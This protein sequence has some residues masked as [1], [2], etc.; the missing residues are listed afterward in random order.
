MGF[1]SWQTSD[2]KE[3]IGNT[4]TSHCKTVYLLQP[5]GEPPIKETQYNGYGVFGGVDAYDWLAEHNLPKSEVQKIIDSG[6][7]YALRIHAIENFAPFASVYI[8]Q[9]TGKI[10]RRSEVIDLENG[11][12]YETKQERFGGRSINELIESGDVV[13]ELMSDHNLVEYPL[14]FS[15]DEHAVY[16]NLPAAE[17]CPNQGFFFADIEYEEDDDCEFG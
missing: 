4:H 16:E 13:T 7:S 8:F 10:L 3:S 2:T 1:F 12:T 11:M 6:G 17:D 15:F 14:K 9:D 5:N